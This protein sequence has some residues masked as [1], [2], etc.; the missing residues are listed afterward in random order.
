LKKNL[1]GGKTEVNSCL[2]RRNQ[3]I[4]IVVKIIDYYT[5]PPVS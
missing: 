1:N 2:N 4:A 5:N 3:V